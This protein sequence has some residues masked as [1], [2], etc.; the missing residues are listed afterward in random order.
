MCPF[1]NAGLFSKQAV[2]TVCE[3]GFHGEAH[4]CNRYGIANPARLFAAEQA[5]CCSR[6]GSGS[7]TIM[8]YRVGAVSGLLHPQRTV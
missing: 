6:T 4:N 8:E 7:G 1:R 2:V 3:K 5:G